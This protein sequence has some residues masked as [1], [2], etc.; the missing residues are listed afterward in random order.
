MWPSRLAEKVKNHTVIRSSKHQNRSYCYRM[1]QHHTNH[2]LVSWALDAPHRPKRV[3]TEVRHHVAICTAW[4]WQ[5]QVDL[6]FDIGNLTPATPLL[7]W[8]HLKRSCWKVLP[9]AFYFCN[10]IFFI[11]HVWLWQKL[12]LQSVM[13]CWQLMCARICKFPPTSFAAQALSFLLCQFGF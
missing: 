7:E 3:A 10:S 6:L 13:M 1:T 9:A 11:C 12:I 8:K 2:R 4:Y 5:N